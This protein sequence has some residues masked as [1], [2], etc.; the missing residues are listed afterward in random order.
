MNYKNKL[1][2]VN[3]LVNY[4]KPGRI[5]HKA[6]IVNQGSECFCITH[7]NGCVP[8]HHSS[9]SEADQKFP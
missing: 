8:E 6:V 4:I 9:H 3:L 7:N 5:L 1:Q 2:I